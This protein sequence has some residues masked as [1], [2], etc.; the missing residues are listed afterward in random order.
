MTGNTDADM[1]FTGIMLAVHLLALVA[2]GYLWGR[3]RGHK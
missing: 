3:Y 1:W 2:V